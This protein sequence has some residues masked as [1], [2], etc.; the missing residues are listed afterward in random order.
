MATAY[1]HSHFS[2]FA[3]GWLNLGGPHDRTT[4]GGGRGRSGLSCP[5]N[6]GQPRATSDNPRAT[7]GTI[8]ESLL[9]LGESFEVVLPAARTGADWAWEALYGDLAPL[10][11]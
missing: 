4:E 7:S 6:P 11:H 5:A 1:G 2:S 10:V 8:K 3:R 9:T